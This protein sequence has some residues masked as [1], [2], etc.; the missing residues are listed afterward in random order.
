MDSTLERLT[1][2]VNDEI[3][4]VS[5][6]LGYEPPP[7][8]NANDRQDAFHVTFRGRVTYP[9]DLIRRRCHI[10]ISPANSYDRKKW[11]KHAMIGVLTISA[12]DCRATLNLDQESLGRILQHY[13]LFRE[14][15]SPHFQISFELKDVQLVEGKT[16]CRICKLIS[17]W[18]E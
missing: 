17:G 9:D 12:E 5:Y 4:H 8:D 18:G 2:A 10:E 14:P 11:D 6:F 3:S 1:V 13:F 7:F 15:D 16:W